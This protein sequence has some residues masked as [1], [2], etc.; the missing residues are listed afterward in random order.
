MKPLWNEVD[1]LAAARD[2]VLA[3]KESLANEL[4]N[5]E[6]TAKKLEQSTEVGKNLSLNAIP[7]RFEEDKLIVDLNRVAQKNDVIINGINFG[8]GGSA[9]DKIKRAPVN[10]N[11]SGPF[12]AITG[13]LKSLESMERKILVKSIAVQTGQTESA[14]SRANFNV[15]AEVYY[16]N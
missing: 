2:V 13:F 6:E 7:E 3:Q 14:V 4:K 12:G 9:A 1:K 8:L 5:L 11:V 10:I 16:R 15:S